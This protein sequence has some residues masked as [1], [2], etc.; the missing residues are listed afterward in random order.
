MVNNIDLLLNSARAI[1]DTIYN[2]TVPSIEQIKEE[3]EKMRKTFPVSDIEFE[4]VLNKLMMQIRHT[5]GPMISLKGKDSEH[6]SWYPVHVDDGYYWNRFKQYLRQDKHWGLEIIDRL[7]ETTDN[8]MDDLGNPNDP[9]RAFQRRGLLLGDVQSGKTATY[10]ALCNKA[11]DAGYPVIIILAGMLENLR[12]QT[13]SRLDKEFIGISSKH[14]LDPKNPQDVTTAER[15]GVGKKGEIVLGKNVDRFTSVESDFSKKIMTTLGL[16]LHQDRPNLFVVK[17][18]KSVLNNLKDWLVKYNA[19]PNSGLIEYPLLL[20]D[21]EADNASVNTKAEDQDPT[22]INKAIRS[23]LNSFKQASYVGITATP[24][25]NIFIDPDPED[26]EARDLFPKDFLTVLPTPELYIGADRIFGRG[27]ADNWESP[28]GSSR[29]LGEFDSSIIPIENVEQEGFFVYK[30]KKDL[31]EDL[32]YLPDSLEEAIRYFILVT[33][34]SDARLDNREHRSMLVNVSRFTKVQNK[35]AELIDAYLNKVKRDVKNYAQLGKKANKV[36]GIAELKDVWDKYNLSNKA[37]LSWD[38]FLKDYLYKAI[39]RIV[40]RSVNASTGASSLDYSEYEGTG[41]RVI[42]VGG[43]SLS[44][45]LTLEGLSVSYFY[46]NTMMYDTLLQMGRWFGYR[47]NYDDLFKIWMG[48]DTIDHYG[49]ITDAV[50]EL[51]DELKIMERQNLSPEKFGLKVRRAPGALLVTAKNKMRTGTMIDCPITVVG[52]M[53]ETPRLNSDKEII[54]ENESLCKDFL[55]DISALGKSYYSGF[56]SYTNAYIWSDVPKSKIVY[57]IQ[58]FKTHPWNLNFQPLAL[59]DYIS[60]E[61]DSLDYWTVAIPQGAEKD[62]QK[63]SFEALGISV[64]PEKRKLERDGS[65]RN[66]LKVNGHHVRVGTG[67]CSKIGLSKD[68]IQ[69]IR[70]AAKKEGKSVTDKTY[71]E[72]ERKPVLLVH[73]IRNNT[74]ENE[75]NE[76]DPEIV[77]ALGLGFPGKEGEKTRQAKYVVNVRELS[78]WVDISDVSEGDS[79]DND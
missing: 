19:D 62:N 28:N 47:P 77:F 24:F 13:Q 8:I 41:M 14:A 39:K 58:N 57:L 73:V 76:N 34:I 79:D 27:D 3:A 74:P 30:H 33:G 16:T 1:I 72:V 21:D 10:T 75:R 71:L 31:A 9:S 43:N 29:V 42:A 51:K 32:F 49:Y 53:L 38:I 55:A 50:N 52:R 7:D 17:K 36:K 4:Y 46:R 59:A 25:A 35:T 40:V 69:R 12:V 15:I 54:A 65:T 23:I 70:E 6:K 18:N 45:G 68:E 48:E 26:D 22:A 2:D 60:E 56:D 5:I 20:I 61:D 66:L 67:G 78:N 37:L 11:A 44:R 64:I 63:Y